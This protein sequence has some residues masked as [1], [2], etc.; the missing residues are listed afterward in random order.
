MFK[1]YFGNIV[2]TP[3][4]IPGQNSGG[5]GEKQ[6]ASTRVKSLIERVPPKE[7]GFCLAERT[8]ECY[9]KVPDSEVGSGFAVLLF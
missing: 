7:T 1:R 6:A 5:E 3:G 9:N 8:V 4:K 2:H